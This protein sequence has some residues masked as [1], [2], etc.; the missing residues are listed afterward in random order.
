MKRRISYI[1]ECGNP[2]TSSYFPH[3]RVLLF[4]LAVIFLPLGSPQGRVDA[5]QPAVTPV[6]HILTGSF[7]VLSGGNP[8]AQDVVLTG[9]VTVTTD[10]KTTEGTVR[11]VSN[12]SGLTRVETNLPSGSLIETRRVSPANQAGESQIGSGT[13]TTT[14][15]HNLLV[16]PGWFFPEH[17]V[18]RTIASS[19]PA[20]I[21]PAA[22]V[23]GTTAI[24]VDSYLIATL[25]NHAATLRQVSE[26]TI[27]FDQ[28]TLLPAEIQYNSHANNS[29]LKIIPTRIV[30]GNYQAVQGHMV[31][32]HIQRY[33][34]GILHDDIT[35][36][37][38]VLNPGIAS[39][40]YSLN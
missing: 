13:V 3:P 20:A 6:S 39:S 12:A 26:L 29:L 16:D 9:S 14:A 11:L 34:K 30:Y 1:S 35:I 36:T 7:G 18:S 21:L 24:G 40:E 19:R 4:S 25:S 27:F 2:L 31:P 8:T 5:Q 33:E 28:T 10:A 17:L 38:A 22:Q 37:G 15:L 32:F 23:D